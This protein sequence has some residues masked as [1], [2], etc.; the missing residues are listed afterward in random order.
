MNRRP[1]LDPIF[2]RLIGNDNVYFQPPEDLKMSYPCI[3]YKLSD[4][5]QTKS[6]NSLYTHTQGYDVVYITREPDS[7]LV[8]DILKEFEMISFQNVMVVN[9]LYHYRY[10]L[11]Y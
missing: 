4:I 10:R 11:Y 5:K 9:N 3:R 8:D 2:K 6:N 1:E 7:R